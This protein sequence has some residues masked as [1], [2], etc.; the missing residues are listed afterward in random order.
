MYRTGDV[1]RRGPDGGL[2]FLGRTDDQ[3]KIR[4]FRVEP[5]EIAAVL[6]S[7]PAVRHAHVAVRQHRSGPRLTAYVAASRRP[8]C[9]ELRAMLANRLPRYLVPHRIVVVDEMPL[10]SHGK[11]DEAALAALPATRRIAAVRA[12]ETPT[13]TALAEVLAEIL[14]AE[15]VDVDADFLRL[16]LDSI[17][18]LS[19]VQAARGA[20]SRCGRG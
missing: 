11:V 16:G 6:H 4:G 20:A 5:G 3:V 2:Q 17:V 19:V 13:E 9:R 15:Q 18:A 7:H 1:V 12:A 14:D 8:P 10:T